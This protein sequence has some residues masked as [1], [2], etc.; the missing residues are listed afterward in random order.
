VEF[1][2]VDA[3]IAGTETNLYCGSWDGSSWTPLNPVDATNNKLFG[4]VSSFSDF[5][6]GEDAALPVQLV[7]FAATASRLDA[8]LRW[9][10]ATEMNNYGFVIERRAMSNSHSQWVK[11]GFV[12]G[13]GT[14]A[15]PKEY[16]YTD[17]NL[18]PGRYA[19]RIKQIDQNGAFKYAAS[20][21]VEVGLAAKVFELSSNYPN[22]FNPSTRIDF[23]VPEDGHAVL[24]VYNMLGQEIATLFSGQAVAGQIHQATFDAAALP[25]GMYFS[26]LEYG[27]QLVIK[28]M[29]LLK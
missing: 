8:I 11:V 14:S 18:A 6:G 29:V 22:P 7:S 10:T 27:N 17:K 3:D 5:T 1:F 12:A 4:T 23:T 16:S 25:T 9:S 15:S 26:K 24:K 2:Y 20:A 13:C 19:Y 28:K 21:E